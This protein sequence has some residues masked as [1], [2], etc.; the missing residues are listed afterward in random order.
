MISDALSRKLIEEL[1]RLNDNLQF[2]NEQLEAYN[3]GHLQECLF[4]LE[5]HAQK[6]SS[7][8][9]IDFDQYGEG[10]LSPPAYKLYCSC[11]DQESA[12]CF[13]SLSF[14]DRLYLTKKIVDLNEK[15][16]KIRKMEKERVDKNSSKAKDVTSFMEVESG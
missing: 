6:C 15:Y 13:D 2:V 3:F 11:G 14:K 4:L 9:Q 16:Q 12:Y 8:G 7:F 5:Q 1:G 10:Q